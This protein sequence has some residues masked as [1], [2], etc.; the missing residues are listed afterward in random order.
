MSTTSASMKLQEQN[1]NEWRIYIRGRLMTKGLLNHIDKIYLSTEMT[2]DWMI[3]DQKAHGL[4]IEALATDQYQWIEDATSAYSAF[5]ALRAHH[6]PQSNNARV[7]LLAEYGTMNWDT[8]Q[9]TLGAYLQRFKTVTR[10]LYSFNVREPEDVTVSKLLATMPWCLRGVTLQIGVT[11]ID[12][13]SVT[14]TCLLLEEEYKQAIRQGEIQ[15]PSGNSY[16]ERGLQAL[17]RTHPGKDRKDRDRKPPCTYCKKSGHTEDVCY[18]KARDNGKSTDT[19]NAAST[20]AAP[21]PVDTYFFLAHSNDQPI[22]GTAKDNQDSSPHINATAIILDSGASSHMTG[23]LDNLTDLKQC[24]KNVT[25][26]NGAIVPTTNSGTLTLRT[27]SGNTLILRDVLH[28]PGMFATLLSIPTIVAKN[29]DATRV[30]F[31]GPK[32][33][34]SLHAKIIATG[35]ISEHGRMYLL[36]AN[37]VHDSAALATDA[38]SLWHQRLG[39]A[40]FALLKKCA[41]LNLGVPSSLIDTHSSCTACGKSKTHR[42]TVPKTSSRTFLPG[43]CWVSDSKGPFR[44]E[45]FGGAKYYTLY[46]DAATRFKIIKFTN[47]LDSATQHENFSAIAAWSQRQTGRPT[48]I[49]RSDNGSEYTS[50]EFNSWLST[51]GIVHETSTADAQWQNGLAERAHRTIMEMALSML[52][53]S[54]MARRW[55]AEAA[56]TAVT[57]INSLPDSSNAVKPPIEAMTGHKP[58]LSK[59]KVFGCKCFLLV[60]KPDSRNKLAPKATACVFLG[61][62]NAKK[63]YKLYDM[64]RQK[65]THGVHVTFHETEFFSDRPELDTSI[66]EDTDDEDNL[67]PLTA[68]PPDVQSSSK[69]P[70]RANPDANWNPATSHFRTP[71]STRTDAPSNPD[72]SWDPASSHF[73]TSPSSRANVP[74]PASTADIPS[75]NRRYPTRLRAPSRRAIESGF[76]LPPSDPLQ[77]TASLSIDG[78]E[79]ACSCL[80]HPTAP[81]DP[82][83]RKE[84]MSGPDRAKWLAAEK[85]EL[86]SLRSKATWSMKPLPQGRKSIG[87]RWVYRRKT[88]ADGNVTR[89]KARLVCQ[90]FSQVSGID[91]TDTFSPVVKMTTLRAVLAIVNALNMK[92]EQADADNAYVQANL[93]VPIYARQ[94]PGYE[95]GSGNLLYL[96]KALYG[97]RQSGLEW[98]THETDKLKLL[99]FKP[100]PVDPCLFTRTTKDGIEIICVYVDDLLIAT[101]TQ[102]AMDSLFTDLKTC[103]E[104][105]RQGPIH[106]LLGIKITRNPDQGTI[107]M[108][109]NALATKILTKF[110]LLDCHPKRTPELVDDGD[111]WH[112]ETQPAADE[113]AYRSIVGS[114]MYLAVCTRPDLAHAVGRLARHVSAPREPHMIGAKRALRYLAGTLHHGITFTTKDTQLTGFS[115]ASWAT[116]PDRKSTTG[117]IFILAGGPV[118]WKS[119]RQRIIALS[120][121][122]SEYIALADAAKEL[123]WLQQLLKTLEVPQSQTLIHCDNQSAIATANTVAITE[124]S[125]HIDVRYHFLRELIINKTMTLEFTRT[126]D[127]LADILTKS[128]NFDAIGKFVSALMYK[129]GEQRHDISALGEC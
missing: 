10:K 103:I 63:A 85:A 25:V 4:I 40:P 84:A 5:K 37:I 100:C 19:S 29:P 9:E 129:K 127:M 111:L 98:F 83:S 67:P 87:T 106:H 65:I 74:A 105:K 42:I 31:L 128:S 102:A 123:I 108:S 3:A 70:L 34:I 28:V 71:P 55:W 2:D 115:D 32:C 14:A 81:D 121:C 114:L 58:D 22:A 117:W 107:N 68:T 12:R 18:K 110:D 35:T 64:D 92:C 79:Y 76:R 39:H 72:A 113:Q 45:S 33:E 47:S 50:M 66:L 109:Q 48:K 56:N 125:K 94:P 75:T 1:W 23:S 16:E 101:H 59:A 62:S 60:R 52:Q 89:Y 90:G 24:I 6:E 44:T 49:F 116:K 15:P 13:Q 95:D 126:Q 97:L 53:H 26:A 124:R 38:A 104:L 46:M 119:I 93:S 77:D 86:D 36:D 17:N 73:R 8:K 118:A 69:T 43:E 122:E 120:T 88:D 57:L 7:A 91:F 82:Q 41:T 80:A 54:G 30:T 21:T 61:Y 20:A 96:L 112:D 99:G 27:S 11:P 78:V 51:Q